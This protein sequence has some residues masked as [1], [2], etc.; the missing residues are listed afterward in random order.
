VKPKREMHRQNNTSIFWEKTV[1]PSELDNLRHHLNSK[2]SYGS[3]QEKDVSKQPMV[4]TQVIGHQHEL[5]TNTIRHS[6]ES[7]QI[8]VEKE[9]KSEI[10]RTWRN[11]I[12]R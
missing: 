9:G 2:A 5:Y 8:N 6:L 10:Y 3:F 7:V 1:R 11:S 12:D 4:F